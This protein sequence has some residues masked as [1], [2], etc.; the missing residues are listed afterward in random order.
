MQAAESAL[1]LASQVLGPELMVGKLLDALCPPT[2]PTDN[3]RHEGSS[4]HIMLGMMSTE[5]LQVW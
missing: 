5:L 2:H 1:G 4:P 3:N